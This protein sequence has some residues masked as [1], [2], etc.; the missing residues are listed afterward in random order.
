M[1]LVFF[2]GIN[3]KHKNQKYQTNFT[4]KREGEREKC[5]DLDGRKQKTLKNEI[6]ILNRND[7]LIFFIPKAFPFFV[8]LY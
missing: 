5:R 1:S 8:M 3:F 4:R 7:P 6:S 2:I